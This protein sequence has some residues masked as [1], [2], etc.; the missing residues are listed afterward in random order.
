[1]TI[2]SIGALGGYRPARLLRRP[3]QLQGQ[4][5][6]VPAVRRPNASPPT[7]EPR[8]RPVST[9]YLSVAAVAQL[10]EAQGAIDSHVYSRF[11][12]CATCGTPAPCTALV[13]ASATFARYHQLPGRRSG[14][15]LRGTAL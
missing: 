6:V 10:D 13:M 14:L 9:T 11:G 5:Q 2:L 12:F 4:E 8:G 15:A 7:G 3:V 1:M